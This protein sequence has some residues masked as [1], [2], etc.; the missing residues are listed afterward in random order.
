MLCNFVDLNN[1]FTAAFVISVDIRLFTFF[2]KYYMRDSLWKAF[3][4]L[5][6]NICIF[7]RVT[8]WKLWAMAF[9][10]NLYPKERWMSSNRH[11]YSSCLEKSFG[12]FNDW[13]GTLLICFQSTVQMV[14]LSWL[15][16]SRTACFSQPLQG[17]LLCLM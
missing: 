3:H 10:N 16:I 4:V 7:S 11:L 9:F 5:K 2:N 12:L 6:K 1:L 13:S 14:L 17:V 15:Q 8:Y